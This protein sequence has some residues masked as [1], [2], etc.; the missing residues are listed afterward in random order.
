MGRTYSL[1][2]VLLYDQ[3]G[4]RTRWLGHLGWLNGNLACARSISLVDAKDWLSDLKAK[5]LP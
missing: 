1:P 5:E 2:P 4:I 3:T